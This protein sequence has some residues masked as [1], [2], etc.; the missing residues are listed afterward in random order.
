MHQVEGVGLGS[1]SRDSIYGICG[2]CVVSEPVTPTGGRNESVRVC[3]STCK[4][5]RRDE[6]A[7]C[8]GDRGRSDTEQDYGYGE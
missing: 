7:D 4:A 8:I 6:V 1:L 2:V 5:S 3:P